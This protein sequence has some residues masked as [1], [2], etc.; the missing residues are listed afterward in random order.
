MKKVLPFILITVVILGVFFGFFVGIKT[1]YAQAACPS[2]YTEVPGYGCLSNDQLN[3]IKGEGSCNPLNWSTLN[4]VLSAGTVIAHYVI[5]TPVNL[6]AAMGGYAMDTSISLAITGSLFSD[7]VNEENGVVAVGW[8]LSRDI[9]N[10]F[11]I[12]VLLYIAIATI[13][14]LSGYGAKQLL[15]TLIVIAFLVNFS[16]VITKMIIDSSNVLAMEFYNAFPQEENGQIKISKTFANAFDAEKLI[17]QD[18]FDNIDPEPTTKDKYT[19]QF[20]TYILGSVILAIAGFAF[21]IFAVLF[22]IRMVV[23]LILLILAPLAF[24]A[25]VLPSAKPYAKKWWDALFHQAFFAPACL[26]MIYL[27]AKMAN[28]SF[29]Q[30]MFEISQTG[31]A[32]MVADAQVNYTDWENIGKFVIQFM[33]IA[34]MLF[35][36]II[37]SKQM[38]AI[39]ADAVQKGVS[40]GLRKAQGYA[41]RIS[42]NL[43][44]R[45][46]GRVSEGILKGEGRVAQTL[47]SL[48]LVSRGLARVSG[49]EKERHEKQVKGYEKGY[50]KYSDAG[51]EALKNDPT[52]YGAKREALEKVAAGRTA[53]EKKKER[54]VEMKTERARLEENLETARASGNIM[55]V[56]V[57]QSKIQLFAHKVAESQF[58]DIE[59]KIK[60]VKKTAEETKATA[61][62]TK[63]TEETKPPIPKT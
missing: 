28:S 33:I 6:F 61:G 38:G 34:I 16:G 14:Q 17:T 35:A 7:L 49:L 20:L 11:L 60:E 46:V 56:V 54:K 52:M 51:L 10:I 25:M 62:K 47:K 1:N 39:G 3:S 21:F 32:N 18:S 50:E 40:K 43:G 55:D 31:L 45:A 48:P 57:A 5:W 23:L 59:E 4:C 36:S 63:K 22:L 58:E 26:F 12:F 24:G 19:I 8:G 53:K 13:L 27:S 29:I 37:V 44:T 15:V 2:G 41:G 30:G 9:V 42:K